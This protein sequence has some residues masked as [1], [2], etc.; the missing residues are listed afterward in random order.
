MEKAVP[1]L[2]LLL[3]FGRFLGSEKLARM[4]AEAKARWSGTELGDDELDLI[5]AAGEPAPPPRK[6][7][8]YGS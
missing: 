8:G 4:E 7:D 6:E 3:D 5:S 2:L 1:D